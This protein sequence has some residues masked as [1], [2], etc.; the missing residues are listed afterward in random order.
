[1]S[2]GCECCCIC[3]DEPVQQYANLLPFKPP[4]AASIPLFF[5]PAPPW[6]LLVPHRCCISASLQT[7]LIFSGLLS[8]KYFKLV[9][10]GF[11]KTNLSGERLFSS[12][13][14]VMFLTTLTGR[15]LMRPRPPLPLWPFRGV[16]PALKS[17]IKMGWEGICARN[18]LFILIPPMHNGGK[19]ASW[20][21]CW[22]YPRA[23]QSPWQHDE[24]SLQ[25]NLML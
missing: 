9:F 23:L 1:M 6:V 3:P 20:G 5:F 4:G 15:T 19:I 21:F 8:H 7:L 14:V 13:I 24:S 17:Y 16:K 12:R 25:Y 22:K 11:W 18:V 2:P 10:S